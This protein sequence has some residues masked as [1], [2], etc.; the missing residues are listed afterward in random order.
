VSGGAVLAVRDLRVTY[1]T[2][3]GPVRAVKGVSFVVPAG[4]VLGLVGESGSGKS[5]VA[6]AVMA[7]FGAE[8]EVTGEVAFR[9]ENLVGKPARELR[10]LW[11]R[12][13]AMVFQDPT[14]TLN[15][16][17]TVGAQLVEVLVEHER[18]SSAA[19][20]ARMLDL[21]AAVQLPNP[22]ETARRYPHQL[23]GGQQQRV[24]I[25]TAL[26]C[27]PAVL[28]LDEP[29]T[30]LDV[31]TE[32]RILD[33]VDAL[34]Q[35]TAAGILYIT[36]NLGVIARL[37][38][39]VAVMYAGE[40]V[41]RGPVGPVFARPRHPYTVAL[42]D[43]LPR[44]DRPAPARVLPAIEGTLPD[45]RA[46]VR[47]CQFA[48]RCA[49][50]AERCRREHPGWFAAAPDHGARC[51][52]WDRVPAP[53][54]ARAPAAAVAP[55]A[56][57]AA[58]RERPLLE[59]ERLVHRYRQVRAVDGVSF[60]VTAGETLAVVGESG[61]GKTTTARC[62]AGLIQPTAGEIRI[63]GRPV[64][65]RPAAWSGG[66]RRR[67][68]IVFQN[69]D[70]TLKPR[71]RVLEAVARPLTL[72]RLA[73]RRGRR[74][75]AGRLL[76]AVGLDARALE[77]FPAQL[78]G[79]Q[80]QRVAIAR[81]FAPRPELVVCDEPTSALDVSVQ[82]TVLNLLAALQAR[83]QTS[84]LFISHDLS[85]VRHI[86]DR[87]VVLYL[88]RIV[89]AG[90]TAAVFAPPW[91]PY[92]EAL[93]SAVVSPGEAASPGAGAIRLE[94]PA[95]NPAAPPPGCPFHPRCPRKLGPVCE[96]ETPPVQRTDGGHAIVCHI[97]AADLVR[98]QRP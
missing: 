90:S 67:L 21:F 60:A 3:A 19:A 69:P 53:G 72:F 89:E 93:L 33:L 92:T 62:V 51:F 37:A 17:L 11:G 32:A 29:T 23:S 85:V 38:D 25:A 46:E 49:L 28:V 48:P 10:R 73:D 24:A 13:L 30:G 41:E 91:H 70:L 65:R 61:S 71:R 98:L 81:A 63:D 86:A 54:A 50:A 47:A 94:G 26:A 88:G 82:A 6:L 36:H 45:P 15:P 43:C 68:Q 97:P 59:V 5:T 80:R 31:T 74:A 9:G 52:F 57:P 44:V 40:I 58:G 20:R 7:A 96:R 18:L 75:A 83:E 4:R 14:S 79:G 34:R 76:E 55:S 42:L 77:L 84:Y 22:A 12:R 27:G 95:P 56:G 39:E 8:A 35:R 1:R 87:V 2:A 66:L 64:P 78:S 16:V